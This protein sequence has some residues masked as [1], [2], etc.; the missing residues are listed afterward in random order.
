[1][2]SGSTAQPIKQ[3][4]DCIDKPLRGNDGK[5]THSNLTKHQDLI[6]EQQKDSGYRRIY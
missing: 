1:M 5:S 3:V 2:F 6:N 4:T